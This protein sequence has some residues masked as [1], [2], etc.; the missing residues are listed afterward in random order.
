MRP[1]PA[2]LLLAL[3]LAACGDG[4]PPPDTR[5]DLVLVVVDT[6]RADRLSAYGYARPTSPQLDALGASGAVFLDATAQSSWTL[7]S[8]ASLLSGRHLFV[9]AKR[10]PPAVPALAERLAAAGYETAAFL[11]NPA[12]SRAGAFDRGFQHFIGR[13]VTQD[14]TWTA[15][16]LEQVLADWMAA[17]PRTDRPRFLYLHFMDPHWPYEPQGAPALEGAVSVRD[18]TLAAWTE[19]TKAAGPASPIYQGFDADRRLI[20]DALSRYDGEVALVDRVIG[21]V[22]A[23]LMA[24]ASAA[25]SGPRPLF[26][27]L[28]ADHGEMLWDHLHHPAKIDELPAAQRTLSNV[29]F[30]DHSYHMF[31]ELVHVPLLAAGPGIPAGTRVAT[32]VENVDIAPTLLRAAGL[33][34]DPDLSGRALQDVLAGT[35]RPRTAIFSHAQEATLVRKPDSS[36]KLVFP[37]ETGDALRMPIQLYKLDSDP[38]ERDNLYERLGK[39]PRIQDVLRGLISLR[40]QAVAGFDLYRDVDATAEDP[41]TRRIL[42]QMGYGG[43]VGGGG[44]ASDPEDDGR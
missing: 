29:F 20:L 11:G 41:E 10:L 28:T 43:R 2:R 18:D 35:A 33:P 5:P 30:R 12:V 32:P 16:M 44:G 21:Q 40:E 22:L 39:D 8:M 19:R 36:Y 23:R 6:L 34:D 24:S 14:R 38:H 26:S 4:A 27:V 42:D 3:L 1:R 31:Q 37:T 13:E 9:N 17:N 7:P 25:P 15:P